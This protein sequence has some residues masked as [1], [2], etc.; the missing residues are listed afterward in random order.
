VSNQL[1]NLSPLPDIL[2]T[3]LNV[4]FCGIN[5][6]LHSAAVGHHFAHP[7]NRFWK[8]LHRSGFTPHLL[9]P[10]QDGTLPRYGL[11]LTNIVQR[12]SASARELTRQDYT[13][14]RA[15]LWSK[16]ERY[17]PRVLA[18]LGLGAYRKAF[19]RPD[20]TVGKQPERLGLSQVW[21]LPNPS[22][23]NAHYSLE[24]LSGLFLNL[25]QSISEND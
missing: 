25:R 9:D 10:S 14:G 21:L 20:S 12:P 4:V 6:G 24:D 1:N 19:Q 15:R 13:E 16:I 8:A 3:N 7:S 17:R 11:G 18:V 2:Q 22:G 5:P 23:L